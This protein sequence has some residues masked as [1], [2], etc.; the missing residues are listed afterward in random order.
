MA[1][2]LGTFHRRHGR[3]IRLLEEGT[4]AHRVK[5]WD[6][7]IVFSEQPI[8]IGNLFQVKQIE[9]SIDALEIPV[10][11][12]HGSIVSHACTIIINYLLYNIMIYILF[13]VIVEDWYDY[14]MS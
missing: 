2:S 9:E 5:S 6:N 12:L 13:V 11:I 14:S 7:G 4:I 3:N 10:G 1:C 8:A